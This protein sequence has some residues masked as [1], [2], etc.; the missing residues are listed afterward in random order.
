MAIRIGQVG[1]ARMMRDAVL[2]GKQETIVFL[3]LG[4]RAV[5]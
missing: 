3:V 1:E 5:A 2:L 4:D